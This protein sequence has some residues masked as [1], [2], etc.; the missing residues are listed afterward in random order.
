MPDGFIILVGFVAFHSNTWI[1]IAAFH[2]NMRGAS[3]N[4]RNLS[5]E[6]RFDLIVYNSLSLNLLQMSSF[7]PIPR[8][9]KFCI[10]LTWYG[11]PHFFNIKVVFPELG[12]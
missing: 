1:W 6:E 8:T 12:N 3:M 10:F 4:Y 2:S 11:H 5:P 9:L 7:Y